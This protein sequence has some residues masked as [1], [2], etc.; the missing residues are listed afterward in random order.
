MS[1]PLF[2]ELSASQQESVAGGAEDVAA[3]IASLNI[4]GTTFISL[5]TASITGASSNA[6]GSIA[7]GENASVAVNTS[8]V[9]VNGI[10]LPANF[11]VAGLLAG[12]GLGL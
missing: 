9:N 7:G 8:G 2:N 10:G 6:Q 5:Q 1:N 4:S 11:N 3:L 12:F